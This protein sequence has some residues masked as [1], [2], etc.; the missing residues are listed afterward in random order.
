VEVV[1]FTFQ[2]NT[3]RIFVAGASG[4]IGRRLV[5]MLVE[6]GHDVHGGTRSARGAGLLRELGATPR[7][8]DVFDRDALHA[9]LRAV[10]PD[11]VV[12]QLT[13][14]PPR[15]E[16]AH[17]AES[18]ARNARIRAE[19]TANLVAA[20]LDA[21]CGRMVAQSIAWAYAPGVGPR[22]ESDPL[23]LAAEGLRA[24][25]IA[26]VAALEAAVLRTPGLVGAVLRYGRLYGPGT[27]ADEPPHPVSVHV[28][29]AAAAARLAVDLDAHGAFNICDANDEVSA[30]KA[31]ERLGWSAR[32]RLADVA[33][34]SAR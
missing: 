2:E 30:A 17:M 15:L 19:G 16:P 18:L 6:A 24:T 7:V 22:R 14:L 21:G 8:A 5:P 3:M 20:A 28:D 13:D 32:M 26:G 25:T 23:D 33:A 12:H 4:V 31:I 34:G 9:A 10:R 27:G 1:L 29:A 11:V